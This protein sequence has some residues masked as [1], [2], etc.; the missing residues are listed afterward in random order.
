M[1]GEKIISLVTNKFQIFSLRILSYICV[2][3]FAVILNGCY[4]FTGGTNP[5]HI[6]KIRINTVV[7][8]SG[9]GNPLYKDEMTRSLIKRFREDNT[10][11]PVD[12]NGDAR[13]SVTLTSIQDATVSLNTGQLESQRKVTVNFRVEYYDNVK[14][15]SIYDKTFSNFAL[16]DLA[17]ATA[18]R[19]ESILRI[20]QQTT[21]DIL[22][23]VVYRW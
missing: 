6:K 21:E 16:Y 11:T 2:C 13:L 17:N 4:S 1:A 12:N 15:K 7:D 22:I 10:L 23:S 20:I 18:N 9:F 8:N 3:I 14:K 5:E 19:D